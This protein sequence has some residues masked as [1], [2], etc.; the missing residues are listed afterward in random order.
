MNG[1][2]TPERPEIYGDLAKRKTTEVNLSLDA[3]MRNP[4]QDNDLKHANAY[5]EEAFAKRRAQAAEQA[6]GTAQPPK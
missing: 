1:A 2:F 5:N 4:T 6:S 3:Y